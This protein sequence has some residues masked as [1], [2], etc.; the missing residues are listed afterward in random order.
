MTTLYILAAI[1]LIAV[2]V[3]ALIGLGVIIGEIDP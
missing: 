1:G 2:V 3:L